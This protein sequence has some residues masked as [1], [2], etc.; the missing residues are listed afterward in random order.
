MKKITIKDLREH[1]KSIKQSGCRPKE[2]WMRLFRYVLR[3]ENACGYIDSRDNEICSEP[4]IFIRGSWR[5][6]HSI[7]RSD[8]FF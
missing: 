3:F 6:I 8:Y 2:C 5:S 7:I 4:E 1:A